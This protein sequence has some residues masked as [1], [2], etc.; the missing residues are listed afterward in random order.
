MKPQV[1]AGSRVAVWAFSAGRAQQPKAGCRGG[2]V[3]PMPDKEL[4]IRGLSQE[5]LHWNEVGSIF[6]PGA[7]GLTRPQN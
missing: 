2:G 6:M 3:K 1:L 5:S 4:G 7:P